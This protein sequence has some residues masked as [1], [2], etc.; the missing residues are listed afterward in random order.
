MEPPRVNVICLPMAWGLKQTGLVE[1]VGDGYLLK[2]G[3]RVVFTESTT[4]EAAQT[5]LQEVAKILNDRK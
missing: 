5:L 4:K 3:V 1:E 2:E